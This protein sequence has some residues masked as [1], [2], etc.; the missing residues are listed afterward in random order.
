MC[1]AHEDVNKEMTDPVWMA[2]GRLQGGVLQLGLI[3]MDRSFQAKE[4]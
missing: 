3:G 2:P 4:T 1:F